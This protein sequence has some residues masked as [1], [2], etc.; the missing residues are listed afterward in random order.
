MS[1]KNIATSCIVYSDQTTA[2][3]LPGRALKWLFTSEQSPA[4]N[5]SMNMVTIKPGN[6][7]K[8]AHSHPDREE[9]IYILQGQGQVLLD[10]TVY[11]LRKGTAVLF[12]PG[13]VHMV[14]NTGDVEMEILCFFAPAATL[15]NYVFHE[16]V[17]FP[18]S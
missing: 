12:P 2:T 4:K 6:S 15:N 17:V 13:L 9:V 10:K 16:E 11:D 3:E 5:F 8:P 7:V 18:E 1:E 14:R